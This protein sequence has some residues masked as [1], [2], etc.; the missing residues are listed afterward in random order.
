[1]WEGGLE[2]TYIRADL[3]T[4][5]IRVRVVDNQCFVGVRGLLRGNLLKNLYEILEDMCVVSISILIRVPEKAG[6]KAA[7]RALGDG[8]RS[9]ST[10]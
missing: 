10:M 3:K 2:V 9:R 4:T 6:D 7:R 5:P 1:M 8:G